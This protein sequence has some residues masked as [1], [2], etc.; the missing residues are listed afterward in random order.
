MHYNQ[1]IDLDDLALTEIL[2][3]YDNTVIDDQMV[4]DHLELSD[5]D[6]MEYMFN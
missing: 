2:Q 6:I 5:D 1:I 4:T 3:C